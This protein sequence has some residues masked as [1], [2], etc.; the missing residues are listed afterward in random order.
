M[1]AEDAVEE[2]LVRRQIL[3]ERIGNETA[4]AELHPGEEGSLPVEQHEA[5][6]L[7]HRKLAQQELIDEREDAGVGAD[8]ERE[9]KDGG[10]GE[11]RTPPQR[12]RAV[13]GVAR[14]LLG[15]AQAALIAERLHGLRGRP[16]LQAG[17]AQGLVRILSAGAGGVGN[18]LEVQ[19]QFLLEILVA[20]VRPH[21][22]REPVEP[23]AQGAHHACPCSSAW[24]MPAI[25]SHDCLS[26]ASWRRP[27]AVRA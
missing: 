24:M 16:R 23:L 25:C 9:G 17:L 19:P 14:Q 6:R 10:R 4:V 27:A 20:A 1:A 21:R 22:C 5:I 7:A 26:F 15:P 13:S 8:A 18:Q 11:A 2:A 12:P 3:A